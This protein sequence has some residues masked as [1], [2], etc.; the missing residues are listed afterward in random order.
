MEVGLVHFLM[1][2]STLTF[3]Q[4]LA[5]GPNKAPISISFWILFENQETCSL[6][7]GINWPQ[8]HK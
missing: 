5:G 2:A 4:P 7:K 3:I 1:E 8:F 6:N